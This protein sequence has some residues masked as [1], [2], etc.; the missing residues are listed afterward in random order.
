MDGAQ[1]WNFLL[2]AALLR[3]S[4]IRLTWKTAPAGLGAARAEVSGSE[5]HEP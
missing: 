2:R 5:R 3:R 4:N 1:S